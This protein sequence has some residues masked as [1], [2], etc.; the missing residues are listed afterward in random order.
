MM[1]EPTKRSNPKIRDSL[2][3][4]ARF[5]SAETDKLTRLGDLSP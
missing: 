3:C 5:R 2:R 1:L 4:G